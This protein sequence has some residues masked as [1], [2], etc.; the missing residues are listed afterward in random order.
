MTG[1]IIAWDE[2]YHSGRIAEDQ[3]DA[4]PY[5][6]SQGDFE[7]GQTVPALGDRVSFFRGR[8]KLK[9]A[10]GRTY[11][12]AVKIQLVTTEGSFE[13]ISEVEV[14]SDSDAYSLESPV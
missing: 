11:R 14:S 12:T 2:I 1:T 6:F 7:S 13:E 10:K 3:S 9:I 5:H 4:F 8:D